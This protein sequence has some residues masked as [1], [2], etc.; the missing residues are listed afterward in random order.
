[1]S[2]NYIDLELLCDNDMVKVY[3]AQKC[4]SSETVVI[5]KIKKES[6]ETTYDE[7]NIHYEL[8]HPN[9]VQCYQ[10]F[11][12]EDY[13]NIVMEFCVNGD[14][15]DHFEK[16]KCSFSNDFIKQIIFQSASALEYLH[17]KDIMHRDIKPNNLFLT[18]GNIIKLGDFGLSKKVQDS[19]ALHT[20]K[21]GSFPFKP[22][23]FLIGSPYGKS[24]DI[25]ALGATMYYF[26]E[27]AFPFKGKNRD[28]P[29][30]MKNKQIDSNIR[31]MILWMMKREPDHRPT[32]QQ[33]KNL[34][35]PF[36]MKLRY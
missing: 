28:K 31:K 22:P 26:I 33:V 6:F 3:Q 4:S 5:K 1:M 7:C 9:I 18:E 11:E 13:Y 21:I 16:S 10:Y 17:S 12:D 30:V 15:L 36:L 35:I 8:E 27:N 29:R 32:I 24:A 19:P 23:E 14:V 25:W 34:E 20:T 2:H